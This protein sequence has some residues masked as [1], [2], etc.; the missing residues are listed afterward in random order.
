[1]VLKI[2]FISKGCNLLRGLRSLFQQVCGLKNTFNFEWTIKKGEKVSQK[3]I[4]QKEEEKRKSFEQLNRII[5]CELWFVW[6]PLWGRSQTK[7][8]GGKIGLVKSSET[9]GAKNWK[10]K[11]WGVKQT[12]THEIIDFFIFR[13]LKNYDLVKPKPRHT[14][15]LSSRV[16]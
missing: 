7:L 8:G 2:L 4:E 15:S 1:M 16:L 14:T 5:W 10:K 9:W 3:C 12:H 6:N 11:T 13:V